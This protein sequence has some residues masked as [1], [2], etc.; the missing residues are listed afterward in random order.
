MADSGLNGFFSYICNVIATGH[1]DTD[2]ETKNIA[3]FASG[4]GSNAENLIKYFND[5]SHRAVKVALVVCNRSEA[6]VIGRAERLGVPVRV[7]SRAEINDPVYILPLLRDYGIDLIVLAGFLLMVPPF[8]VEGYKD[9]IVNIHPSLLPKYGGKGMYG[10]HVHRAVVEAAEAETGITVHLVTDRCDEGAVLFQARIGVAPTDT[11]E[12]VESK[13][14][15][16]EREHF[17]RA[18]HDYLTNIFS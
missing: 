14:H 8:I 3:V 17:P 2:M 6:G 16:L 11:P 18:V 7:M 10:I 15:A 1:I 5:G 9:R 12:D 13:V 4:N